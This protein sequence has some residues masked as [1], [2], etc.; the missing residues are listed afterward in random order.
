MLN[1]MIK[2]LLSVFFGAILLTAP[3]CTLAQTETTAPSPSLIA[4]LTQLVQVLEQELQQLIAIH[5]AI[6]IATP[7][8]TVNT[9]T[10]SFTASPTSGIAPLTVT[11]TDPI[12]TPGL[13]T[14]E[15]GDGE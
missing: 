11:F 12:P 9:V 5:T 3:T 6:T 14:I 8:T 4:A 2:N 13:E 15:Y 1:I 7:S 10:E